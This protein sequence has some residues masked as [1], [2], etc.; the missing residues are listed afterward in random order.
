MAAGKLFA[1]LHER[2]D[3]RRC[4]V[5]DRDA[6]VFDDL[7]EAALVRPVGC[8]LVHNAGRAIGQWAIDQIRVAG[9]PADVRRA[10]VRVV[11]LEIE[12]PLGSESRSDQVAS[13]G[14]EDALGFARRS[15]GVEDVKGMFAIDRL[16]GT[17]ELTH[18]LPVHATNGRGRAT[19]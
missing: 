19:S 7:P 10:P 15:G 6:V 11:V 9:H 17:V 14:M 4:S 12:D 13:S 2:A 16:G 3:R 18:W 5:K 8:S 1:P